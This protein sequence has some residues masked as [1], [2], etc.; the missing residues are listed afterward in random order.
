LKNSDLIEPINPADAAALAADFG[1]RGKE[2]IMK[3][4]RILIPTD[5]PE[6]WQRLLAEPEKHWQPG[7]SAMST[8]GRHGGQIFIKIQG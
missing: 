1:V 4:K 5:G 7:F 3:Q 2:F 6:S 8:G